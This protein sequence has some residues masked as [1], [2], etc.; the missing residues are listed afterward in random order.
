M[1]IL[2]PKLVQ[3]ANSNNS[4]NVPFF[5]S[6]FLDLS[7]SPPDPIYTSLS[8]TVNIPCSL[9]SNI[10]WSVLNESGL[11][12]GSWNFTP[13]SDQNQ[14][15]TLLSLTVGPVVRWDVLP[16]TDSRVII[17]R[18][19]KDQDLSFL[20]LPVSEKIRGEYTCNLKFKSKTLSSK[21]KVEVLQG[22]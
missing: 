1:F 9:S 8:S 20:K 18:E 16:N 12:G 4:D 21:V 22:R 3:I 17:G 14:Q 10:P 13:L 19:L 11:Q 6:F 2:F 5:I 15:Q 7:P